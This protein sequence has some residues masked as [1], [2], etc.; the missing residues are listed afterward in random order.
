MFERRSVDFKTILVPFTCARS[1]ALYVVIVT[2]PSSMGLFNGI[3]QGD[4]KPMNIDSVLQTVMF[5]M[6][7]RPRKHT[8]YCLKR[9]ISKLPWSF[10]IHYVRQYLVNLFLF[11]KKDM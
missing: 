11:R 9:C 10:E 2:L 8:R 3:V 7:E 6:P 4:P 5:T 1:K